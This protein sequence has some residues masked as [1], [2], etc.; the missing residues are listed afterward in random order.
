MDGVERY[1]ETAITTQSPGHLIVM[2]VE[3]AIRF[4]KK[5]IDEIDA[6]DLGEK[7]DYIIRA[8]EILIELD[9]VL[10]MEAG[11]EIAQNLRSLYDFM[12]RHLV[13]ANIKK[14]PE[15]IREVI[16]MLEDLKAGWKGIAG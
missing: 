1:Q 11:G 7:G 15:M 13:L 16:S 3:G 9:L 14:D 4:L 2:L 12:R 8:I 10:D 5:A 6:G